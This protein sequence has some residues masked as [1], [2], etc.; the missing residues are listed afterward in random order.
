MATMQTFDAGLIPRPD[1]RSL[2]SGTSWASSLLQ[3]RLR[4]ILQSSAGNIVHQA[5]TSL[6][7][8][9]DKMHRLFNAS[10]AL[11][12]AASEV[13]M[14]LP[15]LWRRRLFENIDDLHD[16]DDWDESDQLADPDSF[17][18]F[19]R[20]VLHLGIRKNMMLGISD[21][22]NILAGLRRGSDSLAFAFLPGDRIRWSIVEHEG[23]TTNSAGGTTSLERLPN[24]LKSYNPEAW[25]GD[26]DREPTA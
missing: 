8:E 4:T 24:T 3:E 20:A 5:M 11:K 12:M 23:D 26:A 19:L 6:P 15:E 21:D 9:A 18:T 22:G 17:K 10:A 1:I 25:F 14:H 16:P 13:S 7:V 2:S